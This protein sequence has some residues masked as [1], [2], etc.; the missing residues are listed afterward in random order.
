MCAIIIYKLG[1]MI[2][3]F[4]EYLITDCG[5]SSTV[6]PL[7]K[8]GLWSLYWFWQGII[9]AGWWCLA[10]EA[11]HGSISNYAFVNHVIGFLLHTVR[12][13]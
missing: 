12:A 9:L 5:L 10:H 2:D 3:A 1:G 11:G 4:A 8:W 13:G 7:V 6:V